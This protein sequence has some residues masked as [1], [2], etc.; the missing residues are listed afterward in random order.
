MRPTT[1]DAYNLMHEGLL[2]LA[3]VEAVGMRVD[4][5]RLDD[6]IEDVGNQISDLEDKLHSDNIWKKWKRRFPKPSL[7]SRHQLGT[8]LI[9]ELDYKPTQYT[10]G[11]KTGKRRAKMDEEEL[12]KVNLP[13]VVDYLNLQKLK[14][15]KGTYLLGVRRE[16]VGDRVRPMFNLHLARTFR[17]SSDKFNAQNIPIRDPVIGALIRKCFIPSDGHVLV[18]TDYSG[19]EFKI[20]ACFWKDPTMMAYASDA[21]FDIHRDMASKC[22]LLDEVPK[23]SRFF[24]KNQFVFPTLY[25]SYFKNTAPNL[26]NAIDEGHLKTSDD[27]PLKQHLR[28]KGIQKLGEC[29]PSERAKRGT[30][31]YHIK[32][33]EQEFFDTFA[34]LKDRQDKWWKKY[35]EV[36]SFRLMTG[37]V[38]PGVYKKNNL[39]N[40]PVQGPAFH[41]LL[42]D[43]I[44]LVKW[45]KK[46]G[47]RSRIIGQIHDSIIADVHKDELSEYLDVTRRVMTKDVREHWDWVVVPL[48]VEA[49]VSETNWFEKK[50]VAA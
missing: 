32:E 40:T 5:Q 23:T 39:F 46:S 21:R 8:V 12:N 31:E 24:A 16:V 14:K 10:S 45:S 1:I 38:C 20:A 49:E 22:Y 44:Q 25:G 7:D 47:R 3:E 13:F 34:T 43:L 27:Q 48:E 26:W 35:L 18:E 28:D 41:L 6:T 2:T 50:K 19:H 30:F 36:G 11:G 15:L 17:S 37:F 29:D 42:W 9:D 4:V 33:V